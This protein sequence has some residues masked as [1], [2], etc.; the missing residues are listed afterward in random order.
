MAAAVRDEQLTV[1]IGLIILFT[2]NFRSFIASMPVRDSPSARISVVKLAQ[3]RRR[4]V[5][6]PD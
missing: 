1:R 5:E 3:S 6:K 2:S 4:S